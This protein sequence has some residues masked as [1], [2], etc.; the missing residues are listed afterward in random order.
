MLK[1]A[2][3]LALLAGCADPEPPPEKI[4]PSPIDGDLQKVR[5][6][7][8]GARTIRVRFK[9][10]WPRAVALM[11]QSVTGTLLL[12]EGDRAKIS[13]TISYGG[14]TMTHE[15]VCDGKKLWRSPSVEAARFDPRPAHLRRELLSALSWHGVGWSFPQGP[16]PTT[17]GL[18][19]V[20]CDLVPQEH[21]LS[22]SRQER[23]EGG[24][25]IIS[26]DDPGIDYRVRL[27]FD[28]S[29]RQIRKRELL[30][31]RGILWYAESYLEVELNAA[32]S[33]EEFKLPAK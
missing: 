32:V 12:G 21:D 22:P 25:S 5:E 13:M 8:S 9:G 10:E 23:G 2:L 26:H 33:D 19:Y 18:G 29:T 4:A 27:S 20:V 28:P 15:A 30:G 6:T 1:R 16:R 11:P 7:L 31:D 17:I 14:R 24:L 3:L